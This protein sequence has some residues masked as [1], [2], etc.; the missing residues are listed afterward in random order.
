MPQFSDRFSESASS[1]ERIFNSSKTRISLNPELEKLPNELA[2][3]NN[4]YLYFIKYHY[5]DASI[6][7]Q[8]FGVRKFTG[9]NL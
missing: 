7:R 1:L 9:K 2:E 8:I 6:C 4:Y 3:K 5:N